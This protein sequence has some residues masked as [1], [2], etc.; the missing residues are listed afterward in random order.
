MSNP[1]RTSLPVPSPQALNPLDHSQP[2][3]AQATAQGAAALGAA[4]MG[5][6]MVRLAA[7]ACPVEQFHELHVL[8]IALALQQQ[9]GLL[10]QANRQA[11]PNRLTAR[12]NRVER[13]YNKEDRDHDHD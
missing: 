4:H 11:L 2:S 5:N 9:L 10:R 6:T 12:R 1:S 3:Q 13:I 8:A 7:Q